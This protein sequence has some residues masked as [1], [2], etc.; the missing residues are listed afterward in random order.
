MLNN[1]PDYYFKELKIPGCAFACI[2]FDKYN[3]ST[4]LAHS[5]QPVFMAYIGTIYPGSQ[6]LP[7]AWLN[8][9]CVRVTFSGNLEQIKA[10]SEK[11]D[12]T[13]LASIIH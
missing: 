9:F 10:I 3:K 11:I 13:K 6:A 2:Y 7:K 4:E 1:N 12:F 5:S 8:P